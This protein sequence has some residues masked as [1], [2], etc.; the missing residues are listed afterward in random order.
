[1][2]VKGSK[3][4]RT[5]VKRKI[6]YF[7]FGRNN[8]KNEIEE[9]IAVLTKINDRQT[10]GVM[11]RSKARWTEAGERNSK[12]FLSLEKKNKNKTFTKLQVAN[13]EVITQQEQIRDSQCTFFSALYTSQLDTELLSKN[14]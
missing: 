3:E 5:S 1:M 2:L 8:D 9:I 6:I 4:K 13:K 7:D 10:Q 11:V 12:Y 14:K